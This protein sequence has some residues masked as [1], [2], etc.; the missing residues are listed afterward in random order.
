MTL[1]RL[2]FFKWLAAVGVGQAATTNGRYGQCLRRVPGKREYEWTTC[3]EEC[4]PGEERCPL[5]HCQKPRVFQAQDARNVIEALEQHV[6]SVCG[7][8]Y[9]LITKG[10]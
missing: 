8:V 1:T 5:G 10:D 6:C 4:P 2:A 7:T 3:Y 9:V